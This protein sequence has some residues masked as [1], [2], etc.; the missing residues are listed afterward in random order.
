MCQEID[1]SHSEDFEKLKYYYDQCFEKVSTR[2]ETNLFDIKTR[3]QSLESLKA[4]S[5]L[6]SNLNNLDNTFQSELSSLRQSIESLK[7]SLIRFSNPIPPAPVIPNYNRNERIWSQ[8]PNRVIRREREQH[9]NFNAR[10]SSISKTIPKRVI[11]FRRSTSRNSSLQFKIF[12]PKGFTPEQKDHYI[13]NEI[14]NL[15][16]SESFLLH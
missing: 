12:V 5:D 9:A 1:K 6:P 11:T 16:N 10:P 13:R 4:P 14:K 15:I 7:D 8:Y 2:H 3:L